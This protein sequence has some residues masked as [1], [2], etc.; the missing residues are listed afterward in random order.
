MSM[1]IGVLR[2]Y[3]QIPDSHSLKEKRRVM[4]SL[5]D[6]LFANFNVSVA[7]IG[8]ND[9]LQAGEIGIATVGNERRFVES[10]IQK[11]TNHIDETTEDIVVIETDYEI[12]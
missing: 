7:E 8:S 2:V 1:R 6:R 4:R 9:K 3:F 11:V 12:F 10:V 5:K